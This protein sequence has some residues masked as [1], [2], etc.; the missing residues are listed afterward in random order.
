MIPKKFIWCGI[1]DKTNFTNFQFLD[2]FHKFYAVLSMDSM[3][4]FQKYIYILE[5]NPNVNFTLLNEEVLSRKMPRTQ[6]GIVHT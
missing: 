3:R 6:L 5:S 1:N 2:Q 4:Q